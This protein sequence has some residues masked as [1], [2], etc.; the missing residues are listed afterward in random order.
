LWGEKVLVAA[1][2]VL[3]FAEVVVVSWQVEEVVVEDLVLLSYAV[4][5]ELIRS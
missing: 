5:S 3:S 4:K 2:G 1:C